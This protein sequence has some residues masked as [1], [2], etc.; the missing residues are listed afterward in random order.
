MKV[1]LRKRGKRN[2]QQHIRV[3]RAWVKNINT[4]ENRL[5]PLIKYPGGKEGE[6]KYI[7]NCLPAEINNYYEPFVGGG[8]VFFAINADRYF[9]NDKSAD[10]MLLFSCI[11]AQDELFFK[12]LDFINNNWIIISEV[13]DN[14]IDD[15]LD[16]YSEYRK[17]HTDECGLADS[18]AEFVASNADELNRL[19]QREFNFLIEN[20]VLEINRSM[21]NKMIRMKK[22]ETE[23]GELSNEDKISNI[24]CS[25]KSAFY[26]HLRYLMNNKMRLAIDDSSHAAI[27]FFIRQTCYSSMFRYNKNGHFNVPY[28]GISYNRNSFERKIEYFRSASLR[29][30]LEKTRLK[31]LDFYD[32]MEQHE[33]NNDDFVFVDPPYDSDF[34]T[35]DG[36]EFGRADQERLA[37]YLINE[38]AANF[39]LVIKNTDLISGLY[40]NGAKTANGNKLYIGYFDKQYFVS[41]MNRNDKAAKHLLI[42]NYEIGT[43]FKKGRV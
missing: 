8:A 11:K 29:E 32:F 26:F 25:M 7:L 18:I 17:A 12:K 4:L 23:K 14:H 24:E 28:G 1:N 40:T 33:L 39:M 30:H 19:F 38:C 31:N 22:L 43:G 21:K 34:S 10:L 3:E 16:I 35:Y 15:L 9:I 36:N 41:F 13:V 20:F 42:T 6:L 27:Y 2:F 37:N 5:H